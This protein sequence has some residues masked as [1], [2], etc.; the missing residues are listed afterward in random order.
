MWELF[1]TSYV[2]FFHFLRVSY[3]KYGGNALR[4]NRR[5]VAENENSYF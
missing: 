5:V 3:A 2:L 1:Y 4:L